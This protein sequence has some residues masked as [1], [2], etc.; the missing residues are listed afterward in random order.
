MNELS[1]EEHM[2]ELQLTVAREM[3]AEGKNLTPALMMLK[4]GQVNIG[5]IVVDDPMSVA[6]TLIEKNQPDC[7]SFIT[8]AWFASIPNTPGLK[9]ERGMASKSESRIEVLAQALCRRGDK[10]VTQEVYTIDRI[11]R[12]LNK[13]DLGTSFHTRLPTNW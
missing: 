9:L 7:Y 6:I 10:K 8:E 12:V 1:V 11:N 2:K 4:R 5:M 13:M 3:I